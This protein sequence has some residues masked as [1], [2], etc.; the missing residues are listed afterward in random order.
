MS[1]KPKKANQNAKVKRKKPFGK[2]SDPTLVRK[3]KKTSLGIDVFD[4]GGNFQHLKRQLILVAGKEKLGKLAQ[5]FKADQDNQ[6]HYYDFDQDMPEGLEADA[7]LGEKTMYKAMVGEVAKQR[8]AHNSNKETLLA[9]MLESISESALQ[10]CR[11]AENFDDVD[12]HTDPLLL[13]QIMVEKLSTGS[14]SDA[15]TQKFEATDRYNTTHMKPGQECADLRKEL[16]DRLSEMKA[17][18]ATVPSDSQQAQKF[19]SSLDSRYSQFVAQLHNN[20]RLNA[21]PLPATMDAAFTQANEYVVPSNPRSGGTT[22]APAAL[23]TI[24]DQARS[25]QNDGGGRGGGGRGG[26]GKGGGGP[27]GRRK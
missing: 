9:I 10:R 7:D 25:H 16:M 17:V 15:E 2:Q 8:S 12:T 21:I 20:S 23:V 18:E 19:L 27:S 6:Y 1:P 5:I 4:V 11:T 3:V 13:W 26:R 14:A 22:L 24:S